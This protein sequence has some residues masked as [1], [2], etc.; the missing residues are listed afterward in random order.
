MA[1]PQ[2]GSAIQTPVEYETAAFT[3]DY[4][5][6]TTQSSCAPSQTNVINEPITFNYKNL[7]P[8]YGTQDMHEDNSELAE[9]IEKYM[10]VGDKQRVNLESRCNASLE[11]GTK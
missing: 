1:S 5:E 11:T 9:I 3:Q 6:K 10:K 8:S 4:K 7:S 2:I